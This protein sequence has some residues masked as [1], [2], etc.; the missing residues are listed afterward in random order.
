MNGGPPTGCSGTEN[1]S[2]CTERGGVLATVKVWPVGGGVCVKVNAAANLDS[3]CA[4]RQ[5]AA[6]PER[7]RRRCKGS[8]SLDNKKGRF[9]DRFADN[10]SGGTFFNEAIRASSRL[11]RY[12]PTPSDMS[13]Q[14]FG[15]RARHNH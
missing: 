11:T 4:R 2:G 6:M 8:A 5:R 7:I 15:H 10:H 13:L 1:Q 12:T 3:V 9:R 14:F